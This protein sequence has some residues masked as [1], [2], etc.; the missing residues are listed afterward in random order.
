VLM[1]AVATSAFFVFQKQLLTRYNPIELTAYFTWTGT[2]SFFLFSPGLFT[3][4]QNATVEA[5]LSALYVGV[6]LAA[7]AYVTWA[8]AL[9]SGKASSVT[10]MMHFL[11]FLS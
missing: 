11:G 3:S 9:S 5:N 6:F 8:V 1:S 2:L 10:S 7:I 4:I